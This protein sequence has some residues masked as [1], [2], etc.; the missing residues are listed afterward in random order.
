MF[1]SPQKSYSYLSNTS[2]YSSD[3]DTDSDDNMATTV[4]RNT[5]SSKIHKKLSVFFTT[6][7]VGANVYADNLRCFSAMYNVDPT[8]WTNYKTAKAA[9]SATSTLEERLNSAIAIG[10]A[11]VTIRTAAGMAMTVVTTSNT[12]VTLSGL[13]A[14]EIASLNEL[15]TL[16]HKKMV[17]GGSAP[18]KAG[19]PKDMVNGFIHDM[20]IAK[21]IG[22]L[23]QKYYKPHKVWAIYQCAGQKKITMPDWEKST[24]LAWNK[25]VDDI[26]KLSEDAKAD[27]TG[28]SL[29]MANKF[30]IDT[31]C[32]VINHYLDTMP[33]NGRSLA[34]LT[35][36]LSK[37][38]R[39]TQ[40]TSVSSL[41]WN[42]F[43]K[44]QPLHKSF[45]ASLTDGNLLYDNPG[46]LTKGRLMACAGCL[47]MS[48]DE[49][50]VFGTSNKT[51][52]V[53]KLIAEIYNLEKESDEI[54]P[55]SGVTST[56]EHMLHL[57]LCLGENYT[58]AYNRNKIPHSVRNTK[59]QI[60]N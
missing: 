6:N 25:I 47:Y 14:P 39:F 19:D 26:A 49:T 54:S 2:F 40:A 18:A 21:D 42:N 1:V 29:N 5:C 11:A 13:N 22:S 58:Y 3:S 55:D 30:A 56:S 37:V 36:I 51:T 20:M 7:P 17:V 4:K 38:A 15:L 45:L 32:V 43:I 48:Y 46:K 24:D 8:L 35:K 44:A 53:P 10:D 60:L 27:T 33:E 23:P 16:L 34:D 57:L 28:A 31:F 9:F 50:A 52:N 41:A 12:S 59:F